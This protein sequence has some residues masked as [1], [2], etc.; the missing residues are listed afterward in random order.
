M[1]QF[2]SH[3]KVRNV[4]NYI[5]KSMNFNDKIYIIK[6]LAE[7]GQ[8]IYLPEVN[9]IGPNQTIC[10]FNQTP[11]S[12][13]LR[14]GESRD[15]RWVDSSEEIITPTG[16]SVSSNQAVVLRF[17]TLKVLTLEERTSNK[18][19]NINYIVEAFRIGPDGCEPIE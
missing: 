8:D 12:L 14:L 7:E 5:L 10:V 3:V 9:V 13:T 6:H 19:Q 11:K 4:G 16:L 1:G 2:I 18:K 15:S 17:L